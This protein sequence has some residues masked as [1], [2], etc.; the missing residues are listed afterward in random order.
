[1]DAI[2]HDA[3][4]ELQLPSLEALVAGTLAL[5]TAWADPCPQ[6]SLGAAALR[7]VLARKIVSNLFFLQHH[8]YTSSQLR[9]VI[10]KAHKQWGEL[11]LKDRPCG[12]VPASSPSPALH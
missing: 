3:P 5:M 6:S 8:P 1:M 12:A 2:D 11:A 4:D 10:A 7:G 9:P